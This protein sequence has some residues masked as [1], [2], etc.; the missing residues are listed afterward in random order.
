MSL[1]LKTWPSQRTRQSR[2]W[3]PIR[4]RSNQLPTGLPRSAEPEIVSQA[5]ELA[6]REENIWRM[7]GR[8]WTYR[9]LD[10]LSIKS[11]A[12]FGELKRL[13]AG[14]SGTVLS[15]RLAELEREGLVT[16]TVR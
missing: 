5:A 3:S 4:P 11:M 12:R 10:T 9:I 1:I 14:I 7:L 15:E 13:L 16:R 2:C 6:D 8:K